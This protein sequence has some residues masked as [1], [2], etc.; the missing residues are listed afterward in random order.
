MGFLHIYAS[1]SEKRRIKDVVRGV[2][3]AEFKGTQDDIRRAVEK[4]GYDV[5]QSTIS[6]ALKQLGAVRSLSD[7]EFNYS[8]P[9]QRGSF[10][11]GGRLKDLV[12]SISANET[13][14]VV[15]TAPGTAMFVAGFLDHNRPGDLLGTVAGDDT[16]FVAPTSVANT[17][18]CLAAIRDYLE[19]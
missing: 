14:V 11:Y 17:Q 2:I 1:M 6:R 19:L 9:Q 12:F 18:Q 10:Q 5:T 13:M 8:I 4:Q 15:K 3:G 16:I 7:G